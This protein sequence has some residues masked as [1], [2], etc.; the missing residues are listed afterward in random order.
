MID[1]VTCGRRSF[2]EEKRED[3]MASKVEGSV[4]EKSYLSV[5]RLSIFIYRK[6]IQSNIS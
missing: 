1:L 2:K 6:N 5:V 3:S 4:T